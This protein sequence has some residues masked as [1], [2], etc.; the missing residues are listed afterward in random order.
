M[1]TIKRDTTNPLVLGLNEGIQ[2]LHKNL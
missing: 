1:E 2:F